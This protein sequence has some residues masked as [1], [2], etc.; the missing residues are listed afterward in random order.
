MYPLG[1]FPA[2]VATTKSY[3]IAMSHRARRTDPD[4]SFDWIVAGLGFR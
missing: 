2:S 1:A 3:N 4:Q